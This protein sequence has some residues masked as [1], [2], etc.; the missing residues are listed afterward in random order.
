MPLL[1]YERVK[2]LDTWTKMFDGLWYPDSVIQEVAPKL[3]AY[4]QRQNKEFL[5]EKY[6]L[7][8]FSRPFFRNMY[9]KLNNEA[10]YF[11]FIMLPFYFAAQ[12]IGLICVMWC[13]M[14][15]MQFMKDM[16]GIT[17]FVSLVTDLYCLGILH[18]WLIF[19][20]HDPSVKLS[21][22]KLYLIDYR[23]DGSERSRS[24]YAD[25]NDIPVSIFIG[26][27]FRHAKD[28]YIPSFTKKCVLFKRRGHYALPVGFTSK[29][30]V[31]WNELRLLRE[32]D[33]GC[34][35]PPVWNEPK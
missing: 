2:I 25:I 18:K 33:Q 16:W 4:Q 10:L 31:L 6:H 19:P 3:L 12:I 28:L 29:Y 14:A 21:D 35:I 23:T 5:E 34:K 24:L 20:M 17:L 22:G 27:S 9:Q 11:I 7:S 13:T 26:R 8:E 1:F 30:F 15:T 32:T